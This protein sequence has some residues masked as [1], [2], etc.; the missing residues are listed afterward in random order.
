MISSMYDVKIAGK[1]V[2]LLHSV[3]TIQEWEFASSAAKNMKYMK[4]VRRSSVLGVMG[5]DIWEKSAEPKSFL[6]AQN[7]GSSDIWGTDVW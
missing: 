4:S 2:M 7:V 6:R 5:Q 1:L 3:L